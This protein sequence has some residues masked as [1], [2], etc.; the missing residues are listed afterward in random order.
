MIQSKE[1]YLY[2]IECDRIALRKIINALGSS[3]ILF[4]LLN[5]SFVN[6][7]IMRTAEKILLDVFMGNG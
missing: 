3:M 6:V 1:D 7:N 4:G 2:Y 5:G